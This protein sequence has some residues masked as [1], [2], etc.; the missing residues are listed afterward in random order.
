MITRV[1]P[2]ALSKMDSC[3]WLKLL[4]DKVQEEKCDQEFLTPV[5]A[6]DESECSSSDLSWKYL[7]QEEP[8][9]WSHKKII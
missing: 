3:H 7:T 8:S 6:V 9:H 2:T 4:T 1:T 5:E